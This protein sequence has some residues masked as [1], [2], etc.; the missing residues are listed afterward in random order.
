MKSA[1]LSRVFP[2]IFLLVTFHHQH[3]LPLFVA[4]ILVHATGGD[5][6]RQGPTGWNAPSISPPVTGQLQ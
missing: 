2:G 1:V 4:A 5:A 3:S 6:G